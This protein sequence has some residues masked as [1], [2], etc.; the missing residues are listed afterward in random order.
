MFVVKAFDNLTKCSFS[1]Y[2][3]ELISVCNVVTFLYLIISFFVIK[4][5]VYEPF[6]FGRFYLCLICTQEIQL[7]VFVDFCFFK[8]SQEQICYFSL[9]SFFRIHWKLQSHIIIFIDCQLFSLTGFRND[10]LLVLWKQLPLFNFL[11]FLFLWWIHSRLVLTWDSLNWITMI[12]LFHLFLSRNL[13]LVA[14]TFVSCCLTCTA[15]GHW[16]HNWFLI[17]LVKL[18]LH[19]L[20][21]LLFNILL[22]EYMTHLLLILFDVKNL[23]LILLTNNVLMRLFLSWWAIVWIYLFNQSCR[24]HM[25]I[26]LVLFLSWKLLIASQ[27][28]LWTTLHWSCMCTLWIRHLEIMAWP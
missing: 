20:L 21:V 9:L 7:F 24:I 12:A 25:T 11:M 3:D 26:F 14:W 13:W 22:L 1:N 5:I 2:F 4:T 27:C 8:I 16:F 17:S 23:F 10:C 6:K 19:D 28:L 15:L 18:T